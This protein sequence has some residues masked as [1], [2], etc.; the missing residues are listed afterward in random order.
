MR[1]R[2]G[3]TV[4]IA[5]RLFVSALLLGSPVIAQ[6]APERDWYYCQLA[7]RPYGRTVYLSDVFAPPLDASES[8]VETA[9][10]IDVER[11]F[12]G[13]P[14][15]GGL[16]LGPKTSREEAREDQWDAVQSLRRNGVRV[17]WTNWRF[18]NQRRRDGATPGLP[19]QAGR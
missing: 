12:V 4:L 6:E 16:C 18:V 8:E 14:V 2:T 5:P 11:R 10:E 17:V 15:A 13:D 7:D 3:A 1:A 9:F 19:R